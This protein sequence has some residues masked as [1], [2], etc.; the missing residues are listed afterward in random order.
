ME[1][2]GREG[3]DTGWNG[4][5]ASL[6]WWT[7]V[8][9]SS[10]SW[11]WTGKPGVLQSM[12]SPRVGQN[13]ATELNWQHHWPLW[14]SPLPSPAHLHPLTHTGKFYWLLHSLLP[15]SI[16]LAFHL[17]SSFSSF[18]FHLS[19]CLS[20]CL[21]K[22]PERS[23]TYEEEFPSSKAFIFW[24]GG[25]AEFKSVKAGIFTSNLNN[26]SKYSLFQISLFFLLISIPLNCEFLS[27]A[28]DSCALGYWSLISFPLSSVSSTC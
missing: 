5:M 6:T 1:E 21:V 26:S 27:A 2:K 12:G 9:A 17:S 4:W 8:W 10:G 28:T 25:L 19:L 13:W 16:F 14:S 18:L 3:V 7:W 20:S 23:L 24:E 15:I 22:T 11:W